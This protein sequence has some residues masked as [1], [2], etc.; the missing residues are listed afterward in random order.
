MVPADEV[1]GDGRRDSQHHL[2]M[3]PTDFGVGGK[4]HNTIKTQEQETG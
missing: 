2:A 1:S 3:G 4:I